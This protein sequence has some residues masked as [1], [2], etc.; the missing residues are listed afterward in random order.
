MTGKSPKAPFKLLI[1]AA[2]IL[3]LAVGTL[4]AAATALVP[5]SNHNDRGNSGSAPGNA[6]G[7]GESRKPG[8][9][10][11][12]DLLVP[13]PNRPDGRPAQ[14]SG[15]VISS[16]EQEQG[17]AGPGNSAGARPPAKPSEKVLSKVR[18]VDV[19][20][21]R[22]ANAK[23]AKGERGKPALVKGKIPKPGK[24]APF[25][26]VFNE[27]ADLEAAAA[28]FTNLEANVS[29]RF[30][31][32]APAFAARLTDEQIEELSMDPAVAF[33]E[34]D[35]E[36]RLVDP[37]RDFEIQ[38][39]SNAPWGLDRIDAP[40]LPLDGTYSYTRTA[41][42]V[43]TYVVDTGIRATHVDFGGRVAEGFSAITDG[44][45]TT[46]CNGH[47][48]HVA[49]TIGGQS[50]GVAKATTLVPVRVLAC[51][52]AGTLSGVVA[53]LDWI[54]ANHTPGTP[55]VVNMSLGGGASS[56]LDAAVSGLIAKGISVVVAAGNSA[57]DA[58]TSSPARVPAAITV[59]ASAS[60]DAFASY[61]NFG[62]CVDIIAPGSS[63]VSTWSSSDTASAVASGTSMAAPHVSGAIALMLQ[64]GYQEPGI[65]AAN[66]T[67]KASKDKISSMR[68]GTVNYLVFTDPFDSVP[69]GDAVAPGA[70]ESL[71]FTASARRTASASWTLPEDGGSPLTLITVEL[72]NASGNKIATN[73]L[74]GAST[75]LG[76][77]N[78]K[79]GTGYYVVVTASNLIGTGESA[80]SEQAV[81]FIR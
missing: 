46:D 52:G 7:V 64:D 39:Q 1:S 63:V 42:T 70:V 19:K 23:A 11:A 12:A 56:T 51:D 30:S 34:R 59:A 29:K 14:T 77:R 76:Y 75:S 49:G 45:G 22:I 71:S 24:T 55:A 3:S 6:G 53:G 81:A 67:E 80:T 41:S 25:I 60:N 18:T 5:A 35:F 9:P 37:A 65:V 69:S 68:P 61:S 66:L 54:G 31:G 50:F 33:M 10:S 20:A 40:S 32:A 44:N 38:S 74:S 62:N 57:T 28:R 73:Y 72:F 48:T 26:I 43:T 27:G 21:A 17:S 4:P 2:A 13:A 16:D 15:A 58:C 8:V 47:G 79:Q 78:L 36:I